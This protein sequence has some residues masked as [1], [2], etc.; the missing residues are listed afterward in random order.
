M[1]VRVPISFLADTQA[2]GGG[3][4][5]G[6]PKIHWESGLAA[7]QKQQQHQQQVAAVVTPTTTQGASPK[8]ACI[9]I[10]GPSQVWVPNHVAPIVFACKMGS[11]EKGKGRGLQGG[12]YRP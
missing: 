12:V 1:T 4:A 11:R 5:R 9:H 6:A 2:S 7:A 10:A 3:G 8:R